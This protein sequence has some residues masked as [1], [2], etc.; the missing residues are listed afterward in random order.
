MISER[1]VLTAVTRR[2]PTALKQDVRFHLEAFESVKYCQRSLA[3]PDMPHSLSKPA[4]LI[5]P[6]SFSPAHFYAGI[7]NSLKETG[8][9][10]HVYDLPSASRRPPQQ[11]ATL[12]D[13]AEFFHQEAATLADQ[14]KDVVLLPHSYGGLVASECVKGLSKAE[15]SEAGKLGCVSKTIFLT[16]VVPSV[17]ESL[18]SLMG[19]LLP[20]FIKVDVRFPTLCFSGD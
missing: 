1:V 12:A 15:R 8:Y 2:S 14:G 3:V 6:G 9:E 7:V 16:S 10:A 18:Q 4:I 19:S 11:A 17:G 5:I 20:E 13:D